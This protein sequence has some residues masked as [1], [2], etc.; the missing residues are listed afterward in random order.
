MRRTDITGDGQ[1]RTPPPAVRQNL[2]A[3]GRAGPGNRPV[4]LLAGRTRW[5]ESAAGDQASG[6]AAKSQ[7]KVTAAARLSLSVGVLLCIAAAGA[8]G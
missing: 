5:R 7:G 2:M 8:G 1:P 3:G 6:G 4:S